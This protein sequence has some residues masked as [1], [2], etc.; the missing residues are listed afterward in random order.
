MRTSTE[1]LLQFMNT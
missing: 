1:R